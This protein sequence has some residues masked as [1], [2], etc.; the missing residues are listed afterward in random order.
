MYKYIYIYMHYALQLLL[1]IVLQLTPA[2]VVLHSVCPFL[3][4]EWQDDMK[5]LLNIS[6][7]EVKGPTKK[8][9]GIVTQHSD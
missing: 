3:V 6:Q 8:K 7:H 9:M 5:Y 4:W 1:Y 2:V